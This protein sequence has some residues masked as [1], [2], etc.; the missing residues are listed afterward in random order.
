MTFG[1]DLKGVNEIDHLEDDQTYISTN[2]DHISNL[3]QEGTQKSKIVV[4]KS[5]QAFTFEEIL[6]M[7]HARPFLINVL[8]TRLISFHRS[9][10]CNGFHKKLMN[11]IL[12]IGWHI[13]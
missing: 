1:I 10:I 9:D 12:T 2:Y 11:G 8:L 6:F 13:A 4:P 7:L 5:P 3:I